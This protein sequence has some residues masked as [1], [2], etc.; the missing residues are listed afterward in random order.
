VLVIGSPTSSNATRLVEVARSLGRPAH[1]I[2]EASDVNF[3]WLSGVSTIGM[4]AGASTPES[5]VQATITLL[6]ERGFARVRE[7]VTAEENVT[8]PLP[9]ELRAGFMRTPSA[10]AD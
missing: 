3:A 9:R 7:L 8:F 2:Q 6:K 10:T 4:T 5:L 1:L